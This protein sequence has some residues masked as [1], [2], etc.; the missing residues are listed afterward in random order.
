[1]RKGTV[2]GEVKRILTELGVEYGF[3]YSDN[4]SDNRVG[5]KLTR[6]YLTEDQKEVVKTKMEQKGF[7]YHFIR[8]NNKS[9]YNDYD[10][11]RF[12]FSKN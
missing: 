7:T 1:M 12:C 10:G 11:T 6:C 2:T 4:Y 8:E 9:M 3:A 5:A